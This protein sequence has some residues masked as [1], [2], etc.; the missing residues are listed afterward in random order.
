MRTA[1][2]LGLLSIADAIRENWLSSQGVTEFLAIL[3]VAMIIMDISEFI[4][5][6]TTKKSSYEN[7]C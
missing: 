2:F 4:K 6:M 5:K 3:T 1:I 7:R